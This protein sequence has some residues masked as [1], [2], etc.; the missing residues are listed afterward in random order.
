MISNYRKRQQAGPFIIWGLTA[1]LIVG[2]LIILVIWLFS[3]G[4]PLQ[5]LLA[6]DTPTATLTFTP[7]STS[8]A[9]STPTETPTPTVTL[10]PT[11]S[12]PFAYEI[13]SGDTLY[14][15]QAKFGLSDDFLCTIAALN[16]GID[17][18]IVAPG[19]KITLPNPGLL[20]PTATP[21]DLNT[22]SRGK[23][24]EYTIQA[25]DTLASI[26]SFFNSTAEDI[27]AKNKITDANSIFVG[28]VI[29]VRANLV[30]P[31]MTSAPTITPGATLTPGAPEAQGTPTLTPTP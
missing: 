1:L 18:N 9:T 28:Q 30:T 29:T 26:A 6:T 10:T 23:E 14:G 22:L 4:S 16:P 21:I 20:C 17:V 25:G 31:T 12:A 7:T 8:T 24:V 13:Q 3:K 5:A 15:L 27:I 19:Q 11:A 2:G